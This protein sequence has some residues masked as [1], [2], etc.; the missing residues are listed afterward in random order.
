MLEGAKRIPG[1]EEDGGAVLG[2]AQDPAAM[3]GGRRRSGAV[4]SAASDPVAPAGLRLAEV[5]GEVAAEDHAGA[6]Q[7]RL[8]GLLGDL[9]HLGGLG[10]RE[11]VDVAKDDGGAVVG[12]EL[13]PAGP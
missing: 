8:E 2:C 1:V 9:E 7:A 11:T 4:P 5:V 13:G 12:V 3:P 6:V 10:C